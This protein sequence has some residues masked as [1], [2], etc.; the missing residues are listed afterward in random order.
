MKRFGSIRGATFFRFLDERQDKF[1]ELVFQ[2][3]IGVQRH[4]NRIALRGAM[5]VLRDGDRAE[6]RV[7]DRRAGRERTTARGR[8]DDAVGFALSE[9]AQD[10]IGGGQR[11]DVGSWKRESPGARPVEHRTVGF[12]IGDW[13]EMIGLVLH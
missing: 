7:L 12:K 6:C 3:M 8:S 4:V 2:T 10:S 1:L 9:S 11:R 13:H 5:N